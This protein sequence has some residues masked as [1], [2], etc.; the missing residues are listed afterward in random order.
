MQRQ[1][2]PRNQGVRPRGRPG[3]R[4]APLREYLQRQRS[5]QV[6][7]TLSFKKIEEILGSPLPDSAYRYRPWWANA[8]RTPASPQGDAWSTAGYRVTRVSL[9]ERQVEFTRRQ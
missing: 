3:G 8:T 1:P 2:A 9:A 5:A 4:Y 7:V 6:H